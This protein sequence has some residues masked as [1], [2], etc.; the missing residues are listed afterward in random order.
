MSLPRSYTSTVLA[1]T[2]AIATVLVADHIN[3][4]VPLPYIDEIFHIP[5]AQRFCDSCTPEYDPKLT[6]PPGLYLVS[7]LLH[8]VLPGTKCKDVPFLRST[9]LILLM[10]IPH[11]VAAI[12][13]IIQDQHE[14]QQIQSK[15]ANDRVPVQLPPEYSEQN[16]P[17]AQP[18]I[19][20]QAPA[21]A[22]PTRVKPRSA[23]IPRSTIAAL[24]EQAKSEPSPPTAAVAE[25]N[26]PQP[27]GVPAAR[28]TPS[29]EASVAS[30]LQT[31]TIQQQLRRK[32]NET[33][34]T[35]LSHTITFLPPLWFFGFLYYTDVG[36]LC[37]VLASLLSLKKKQPSLAAIFGAVSLLF[38]QTNVVWLLFIIGAEILIDLGVQDFSSLAK[39]LLE[40]QRVI[41]VAGR[42]LTPFVPVFGGFV[43][44]IYWNGSIVLGDKSNHQ[45]GLHFPQLLYFSLFA[46]VFG[47]PALLS[48]VTSSSLLGTPIAL[49]RRTAS[50]PIRAL[51]LGAAMAVAVHHNTIVHPFLLADNRH[52]TFY[53]WRRIR[54]F[55]LA[56]VPVYLVS[57]R[58]WFDAIRVNR[59]WMT[60]Y[61]AALALTLV[62]SPLIEPR[63][64]II[65]YVL[66]RIHTPPSGNGNGNGSGVRK[67]IWL[68]IEFTW[69]ALINML[70]VW[71]FL[72]RPF[73]WPKDGVDSSRNEST[74]MR[75]MW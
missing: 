32:K 2:F 53:F 55:P 34:R 7:K 57:V 39:T 27:A 61:V 54:Q 6:T 62:P 18:R 25:Q 52:F 29:A 36:S 43:Y 35:A 71:L 5:Q 22:F 50:A 14:I 24:Q 31:P 38:R 58:M 3:R 73:T 64:F 74:T 41:R 70:S 28:P 44:F 1:G 23:G 4:V 9:N 47:W 40:P 48:S 37:F 42:Y 63:Y 20:H 75:F 16:V 46:A 15:A 45:A 51:L 21:A 56:L 13:E 10:T 26:G 67:F 49:L 65:P 12:I 66:L 72:Y 30:I 68:A 59:V 17:G 8:S 11:L 19:S 60:G 69:L 33:W